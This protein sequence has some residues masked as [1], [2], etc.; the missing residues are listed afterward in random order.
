MRR[1]HQKRGGSYP[2]Q[3]GA[4]SKGGGKE[5]ALKKLDREAE[6]QLLNEHGVDSEA[7]QGYRSKDN[8]FDPRGTPTREEKRRKRQSHP[9]TGEEKENG[10]KRGHKRIA[11]T[12]GVNT[13]DHTKS[14]P[15]FTTYHCNLE[16][17]IASHNMGI[18]PPPHDTPAPASQY[19]KMLVIPP[20]P[21]Y[22]I[23][24]FQ[25]ALSLLT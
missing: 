23:I 25:P 1:R 2:A 9:S 18:T 5:E 10:R 15:G 22:T 19:Y 14:E 8:T 16:N 4:R 12:E 3:E 6:A 24:T 17:D 20:I 7:D 21:S 13:G 11:T